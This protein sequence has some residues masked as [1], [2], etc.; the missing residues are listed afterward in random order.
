[1]PLDVHLL[2]ADTRGAESVTHL[3][4]AGSSLMP[5]PVADAVVA[6]LRREEE[7]GGYEAAAEASDRTDRV[8]AS[9]AQLISADPA[10]IA[11]VESGTSA[12]ASAVSIL[13]LAGSRV[14]L[15]RTEYAGNVVTLRELAR[16]RGLQLVVLEDDADGRVSVDHLQQELEHDDVGLVALTHVPMVGGE[17]NDA[18]GVGR[19]CRKA[20]VPFVLD[21][22]QSVGQLPLDVT[23]LECDVLV[24]TGRK[25]LRGP[26]GSGFVYLDGA[27]LENLAPAFQDR[28]SRFPQLPDGRPSARPLESRETSIATRLGLGRAAEYALEVGIGDIRDR[29]QSLA[30]QMRLQLAAVPGVELHNGGRTGIVTFSIREK[31]A[32]QVK[33]L[34][35]GHGI[36]VSTVPLPP[37]TPD[38]I[39]QTSSA[40]AP[41][42]VRA[43]V[44]CY[45]TFTEIDRLVS[46]LGRQA[47]SL[48]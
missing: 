14:L 42:G 40:N 10:G 29:I 48:R 36:H 17:V 1:M 19:L 23:E 27:V 45:N 33:E 37:S 13:P 39:L 25:F 4:N 20:G 11:V 30:D 34:L 47:S 22:C 21:A 7:T 12:W 35:T 2:R 44:H 31:T 32:E 38:G 3:N 15:G 5:R 43:S 28:R 9:L 16:Q 8:Y 26:R 41:T 18:A 24:G 6:H 46:T